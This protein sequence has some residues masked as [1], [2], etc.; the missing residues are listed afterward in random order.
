VLNELHASVRTREIHY[1]RS[2]HGSEVDFVLGRRG[3]PPTAIECKW[4]ADEFDP[5]GLKAFRARYPEGHNI[6]V[7]S[8]VDAPLTRRLGGIPVRLVGLRDLPAVLSQTNERGRAP[9]REYSP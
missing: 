2:K 9:R 6:V 8:D 4:S 1:W 5:A 7:A 3:G